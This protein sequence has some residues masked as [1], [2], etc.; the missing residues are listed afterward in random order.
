MK[1]TSLL[2]VITIV[3]IAVSIY[4]IK[5]IDYPILNFLLPM[6]SGV[7]FAITCTSILGFKA[8]DQYREIMD[9]QAADRQLDDFK[10]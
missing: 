2:I 5:V 1:T 6:L 3:I 4:E 9:K 8:H 10:F 7:L